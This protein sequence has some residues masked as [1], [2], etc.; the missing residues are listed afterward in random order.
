MSFRNLSRKYG[1]STAAAHGKVIEYFKKLPHV[2]D[3]TR[4]YCTKFSG[5]L[6]TDGTYI[7]I[8]SVGKKVP[9]I[10]G[11]DYNTHDIPT[12]KLAKS[13]SYLACKEFFASCNLSGYPLSMLVSDDNPNIYEACRYIYG[14]SYH[15][16]C[17]NHFKQSIRLKLGLS[18]RDRT[19]IKFMREIETILG[20]KRS[21]TDFN[22]RAAKITKNYT[23]N[24]LYSEILISIA[25][26]QDELLAF[27]HHR[28]T[29]LTT[30][31]I[32][33][34]NKHLKSRTRSLC[35]FED[36]THAKLW[37]NAYFLHR[38]SKV[39]TDCRGKFKH[40]N[41]KTSLSKTKKSN[42]DTPMFF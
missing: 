17:H 29:P 35:Y 36:F 39:F 12:F 3:V 32:E 38:R 20:H 13:E 10:Y 1:I 11:V 16:L 24:Q 9:V 31:L 28:G 41:G 19:H 7:G 6:L 4:K 18:S 30:N 15:Q 37:L 14:N 25:H 5:I 23:S 40:L 8:N 33:S 27:H 42:M 26:R 2:A 34:Y 22:Q 21:L